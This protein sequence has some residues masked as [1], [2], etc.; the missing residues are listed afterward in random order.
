MFIALVDHDKTCHGCSCKNPLFCSE[1]QRYTL[2]QKVRYASPSVSNRL[3]SSS[4]SPRRFIADFD[5]CAKLP[6]T[7]FGLR[8]SSVVSNSARPTSSLRFQPVLKSNKL[9]PVAKKRL[10]PPQTFHTSHL[11]SHLLTLCRLDGS[12]LCK[13]FFFDDKRNDGVEQFTVQ[14]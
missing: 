14:V 9:Q 7:T 2:T 3:R 8:C 5:N 11:H 13:V 10:L 6:I 12:A 1:C 4:F